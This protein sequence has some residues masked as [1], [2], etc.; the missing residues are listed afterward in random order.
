MNEYSVARIMNESAL[1]LAQAVENLTRDPWI[2]GGPCPAHSTEAHARLLR[3]HRERAREV[4][5][6]VAE[7]VAARLRK[8]L[9]DP[10]NA[11]AAADVVKGWS[12]LTPWIGGHEPAADVARHYQH[13]Y[14]L[15]PVA[16]PS[17][18]ED[19]K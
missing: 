18:Q 19:R 14:D 11:E 4:L 13:V 7:G 2:E 8:F 16:L 12:P 15:G 3:A 6:V 1:E 9:D 10:E 17:T 5:A